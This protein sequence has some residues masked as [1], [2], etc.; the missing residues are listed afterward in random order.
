VILNTIIYI[1]YLSTIPFMV[2][3]YDSS[4]RY[5]ISSHLSIYN[6]IE[7]LLLLLLLSIS[8]LLLVRRIRM[9]VTEEPTKLCRWVMISIIIFLYRFVFLIMA[10]ILKDVWESEKGDL[11]W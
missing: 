6:I 7:T 10:Q 9:F 8:G 5:Y 3:D 2:K 11:T 4:I 1:L